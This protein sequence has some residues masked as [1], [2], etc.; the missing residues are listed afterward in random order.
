MGLFMVLGLYCDRIVPGLFVFS[1][2]LIPEN[3][4][5]KKSLFLMAMVLVSVAICAWP[6]YRGW[7]SVLST[8]ETRSVLFGYGNDTSSPVKLFKAIGHNPRFLMA[9]FSYYFI[10]LTEQ[11]LGYGF[12][13]LL[14]LGVFL[15][16]RLR[17]KSYIGVLLIAVSIP[18]LAFI[19]S[20]K[21]DYIYLSPLCSYFAIISGLGIYFVRGKWL[22]YLLILL[23]A[24]L[25]VQ[26]YFVMFDPPRGRR[27]LFFSHQFIKMRAQRIPGLFLEDYPF[28]E[29]NTTKEAQ[30]IINWLSLLVYQPAAL[31]EQKQTVVVDLKVHTLQHSVMFLLRIK[32]PRAKAMNA[33]YSSLPKTDKKRKG[34]HLYLLS[35]REQ[36]AVEKGPGICGGRAWKNLE[37]LH[38]LPGSQITLY[39]AEQ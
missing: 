13:A 33:F 14:I 3:F 27:S 5:Q 9:H 18:L 30:L 31:D 8:A 4:R 35:D 21:K 20:P 26:Q 34:E 12:T 39:G 38:R 37:P 22:R 11:L 7:C 16:Y 6:F 19:G 24:A 29:K 23:I 25:T 28:P 32:H 15:L 17:K 2:F 1:L 36:Y 10:A